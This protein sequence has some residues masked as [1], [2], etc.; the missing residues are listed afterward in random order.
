[1]SKYKKEDKLEICWVDTF[2]YNGWYNDKEIDEKTNKSFIKE[3]GYLI[4][5]T[6]DYYIICMGVETTES[7]FA[8]YNCPKWIPKGFIKSIRKLK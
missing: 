4:K 6:E 5:E 8:P 2:G 1:M 7:D 3:I